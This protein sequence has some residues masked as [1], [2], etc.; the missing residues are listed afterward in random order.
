MARLRHQ[1]GVTMIMLLGLAI[2]LAVMAGD[3]ASW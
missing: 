1:E 3:A 2:A